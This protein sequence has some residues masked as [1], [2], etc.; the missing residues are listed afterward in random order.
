M[1]TAGSIIGR[2]ITRLEDEDYRFFDQNDLI[3]AYNDALD[4]I[5][6]ATEISETYITVKRRKKALY[7]DLRAV[8]P[9]SALRVTAVWNLAT[10]KWLDPTTVT[11][12]DDAHGRQW[13]D[14]PGSSR[15]WFMRGLWFLG[16]YPVPGDDLQ[17]LRI[18][19]A[20]LLSHISATGG[21]TSGLTSSTALP[22]DFT[23]AIENYMLYQL[24]AQRKETTKSLDHFKLYQ[25]HEA[26]LVDLGKNRMRRDKTPH[27]GARRV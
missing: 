2:V 25:L 3:L 15:W 21:L 23:D 7:A 18:H 17:S 4:E 13:E 22:P 27:M 1:D 20:D 24:W 9:S 6:D 5:S 26:E 16:A 14:K 11:E 8:L 12:L 10:Q 19:Y